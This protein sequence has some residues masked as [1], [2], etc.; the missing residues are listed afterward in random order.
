MQPHRAPRAWT[1][2]RRSRCAPPQ[3]SSPAPAPAPTRRT[4]ASCACPPAS[5]HSAGDSGGW[6]MKAQ[7]RNVVVAA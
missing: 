3:A 4:A 7:V 2:R 1:G 6:E 5:R